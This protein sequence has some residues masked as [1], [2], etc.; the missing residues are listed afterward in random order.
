[1][2]KLFSKF[3]LWLSVPF[4]II[5]T[6]IW[7]SGA[8]LVFETEITEA[9]NKDKY[10]V[11]SIEEETIPVGKLIRSVSGELPDSVSITGVNISKDPYRAYQFTLSQPR[12]ASIYVNQY[13]GEIISHY[14]RSEFFLFF[15]KLHRWLLDTAKNDGSI[16]WGN[17]IVG[18]STILFIFILI[19]AAVIWFPKSKAG[20]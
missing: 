6:I 12:R 14:K 3:H 19:T 10:Y 8:V 2:R 18:T 5:I 1:M 16:Y 20:Y 11:Q 13:N 7:F 15:F 4:G 9:L 17:V